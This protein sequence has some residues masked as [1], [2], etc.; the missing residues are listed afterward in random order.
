ML[1][2]VVRHDAPKHGEAQVIFSWKYSKQMA[3]S[4]NSV[5]NIIQI[6]TRLQDHEVF[7]CIELLKL[8][9]LGA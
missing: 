5:R 1:Q 9:G 2:T 8:H 7:S 3:S 6:T 4:R